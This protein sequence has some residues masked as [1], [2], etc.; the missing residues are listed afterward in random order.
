M[1]HPLPQL[2]PA[3]D[4]RRKFD[5]CV[6]CGLCLPACPTYVETLNEA[7]SPRGRIH[8]MKA[9]TDGRLAPSPIV[10]SHLDSCL[11]CRGC[12]TA[13]PSNVVYHE[14]LETVR[15]Q[16]ARAVQRRAMASR[17]LDFM[18]RHMLPFPKRA[19]AAMFPLR[20]ARK[21]GLGGLARS[22]ARMLPAPLG[23]MTD[24]L[25]DGPLFTPRIPAFTPAIAPRRGSVVLLVGC[26]GSL[27]SSATNRAAIEVL[28]HNGY[29][30]HLLT[31]ETC[32]GALAAHAN[33]PESAADFAGALVETL[34]AR[35]E[36]YFISAIAGCGAQLKALDHALADAP[37]AAER[38]RAVVAKVRD[39]CEFLAEV[40]LRPPTGRIERTI[41]YHDPCHLQHAQKITAAPRK[42]LRQIPGITLVPLPESELCCGAAGTYNL[43]QPEMAAA[44][45]RRKVAAIASTGATLCATANVGC[46]L[47]ISRKLRAASSSVAIGHVVTLL[48]ESYRL[49]STA[50]SPPKSSRPG[51]DGF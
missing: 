17:T 10:L 51:Q 15:P 24:V 50:P 48:A 20:L 30:V 1:S 13:C 34:A 19:A 11:V 40:G 6:H 7:D 8:L 31:N 16:I 26:V 37:V 45:G 23:D 39:I 14:I 41:T 42:L 4:L 38:A 32:C 44:L 22:I 2:S 25:P 35:N 49:G 21:I 28:T 29:D 47:H 9:V 43:S 12:E 27:V 36:D 33:D 3:S 18:V 46:E 5:A